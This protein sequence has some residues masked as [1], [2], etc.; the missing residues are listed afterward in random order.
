MATIPL[1]LSASGSDSNDGLTA[2]TPKLTCAAIKTILDAAASADHTI[3]IAGTFRNQYFTGSWYNKT[4]Q[5][6][7]SDPAIETVEPAVMRGDRLVT[8][9]WTHIG[10]N[11]YTNDTAIP[12][13]LTITALQS[14]WDTRA[15]TATGQ[16]KWAMVLVA[17]AAA[18]STYA[19][20]TGGAKGV[21][22]YASGTGLITAYF[23]GENPNTSGHATGYITAGAITGF[24][25]FIGGNNCS[26]SGIA[27]CLLPVYSGQYG[28]GVRA[29]GCSGVTVSNCIMDD[30]GAHF[31]GTLGGVSDSSNFRMNGCTMRGIGPVAT[32]GIFHQENAQGAISGCVVYNCIIRQDRWLGI[33]GNVVHGQLSAVGAFA[34]NTCVGVYAHGDSGNSC[35]AAGGIHIAGCTI[36]TTEG[37]TSGAGMKPFCCDNAVAVTPGTDEFDQTKF[38]IRV[39]DSTITNFPTNNLAGQSGHV[40]VERCAITSN[41]AAPEGFGSSGLYSM[42]AVNSSDYIWTFAFCTIPW[43]LDDTAAGGNE[44]RFLNGDASTGGT[45]HINMVNCSLLNTGTQNATNFHAFADFNNGTINYFQFY[46]CLL[47]HNN[48]AGGIAAAT[49]LALCTHDGLGPV[50][51][52][53]HIFG[54]N[55]FFNINNANTRWS[56]LATIDTQAEFLGVGNVDVTGVYLSALPYASTTTLALTATAQAL[57]R[58]TTTGIVGTPTGINGMPYAGNYGAWQ[59]F[60]NSAS[61][62]ISGIGPSGS[63]FYGRR[64]K[65]RRR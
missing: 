22:H 24:F 53:N 52:A 62:A 32:F 7:P 9:N 25:E 43:S 49:A 11:V 34:A 19:T 21:Y 23:G 16:H 4:F 1:Y 17:T 15:V 33:D 47:I 8:G 39:T 37:S 20:G 55:A 60:Q 35:I 3:N 61:L 28:W 58:S 59:Y 45:K 54:D 48:P 26:V 51:K 40:F 56:Q 2:A 12:T 31:A 42:T 64:M 14:G 29:Q 41:V 38:P 36:T 30:L 65:A 10:N 63:S 13:G 18:V 27:Q 46:G 5:Q 57:H 50:T 44:T 6:W